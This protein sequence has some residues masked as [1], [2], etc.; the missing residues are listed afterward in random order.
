[1]QESSTG[2]G[3]GMHQP[4]I[5]QR[6]IFWDY[7]GGKGQVECSMFTLQPNGICSEWQG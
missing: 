2:A 6:K 4:R 7:L 3:K 5:Q 1:M